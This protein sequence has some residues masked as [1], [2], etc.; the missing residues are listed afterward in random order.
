LRFRSD[1]F[2]CIKLSFSE[3]Y[4]RFHDSCKKKQTCSLLPQTVIRHRL[5]EAFNSEFSEIISA[6]PRKVILPGMA[7]MRQQRTLR[8]LQNSLF[9][10]VT[11]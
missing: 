2:T 11:R 7:A 10:D 6:F 9:C 1:G 3:R 4:V 5:F 8:L